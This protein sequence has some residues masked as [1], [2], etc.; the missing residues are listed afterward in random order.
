MFIVIE[1]LDG[2]G[3]ST[4]A[5][6]LAEAL[7][8]KFLTTPLDKFKN[9]RPELEEIYGDESLA[10][11]LFYASTAVCSSNRVV[12]ELAKHGCVVI[13]RYWLSTQV[14]H[15][16][17]TGGEHFLLPEVEASI[18]KPDLT[19]YLNISLEV[20][21]KRLGG[22]SDNTEEDRLTTVAAA[23]TKLNELYFSHSN[24]SSVGQWLAADANMQTGVIVDSILKYI[25]ENMERQVVA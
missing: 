13:D 19:V 20:R 3:K 7:G 9:V 18:L 6:T 10:R 14:Y 11:Q 25:N 22:R 4:T 2:T 24:S 1:G 16:W 8:G 5:K 12:E 17:R 15:S 23:N 21:I